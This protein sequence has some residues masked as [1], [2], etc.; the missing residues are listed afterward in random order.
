MESI[1]IVVIIPTDIKN[2]FKF[3]TDSFLHTSITGSIAK[4]DAKAGGKFTCWDE[5][6][7][8]SFVEIDRPKK[9]VQNWRTIEFPEDAPDS[10]LELNFE[11]HTKG[12]KMTL[13]QTSIPDGQAEDYKQGWVD[14]YFDLMKEYFEKY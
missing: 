13:V 4:I 8:G 1:K 10:V 11:K 9:I 7:S 12:T 6:I 14:N 5:Y 3:W 2:V